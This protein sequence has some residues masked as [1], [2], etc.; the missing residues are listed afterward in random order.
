MRL[1]LE[2]GTKRTRIP[3]CPEGVPGCSGPVPGFTDTRNYS[4][5]KY[6]SLSR[7]KNMEFGFLPIKIQFN[8][9]VSM[10]LYLCV[11]NDEHFSACVHMEV[12][13]PR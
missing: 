8:D 12:G 9:I 11:G 4:L 13:D 5:F 6:L 1:L 2:A 10:K 7:E 3:G